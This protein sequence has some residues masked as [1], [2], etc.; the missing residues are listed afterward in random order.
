M[1]D[2]YQQALDYLYSFV[3]FEHRHIDQYAPEN[4]SLDRP[5]RLLYLLGD[6]H[7]SLKAIHIAGTKGKGSVAAMCAAS[8]QAAGLKVGLYTSPHLQSLRER[9]RILVEGDDDGKVSRDQFADLVQSIK[10]AVAQI[11]DLTWYELL[12]AMAFLH[13]DR[14]QVDIAVVEVGLG[15][16]LDATNLLTPLV[17]VITSLSLDHTYL[18]GDT[19]AEIAYEKGGII[20]PGVPVVTA[21]QPVE[22][23]DRLSEIAQARKAPLLRVGQE[24]EYEA[25]PIPGGPPSSDRLKQRIRIKRSPAG[26]FISPPAEFTLAL[27][28]AHQQENAVVALAALSVVKTGFPQLTPEAVEKG[29]GNVR[30]PG[31]LQMMPQQA[32]QPRVLLDCAHNGDSARKLADAL[33]HEF[34]FENLCLILGISIDKDIAGILSAL[35]PLTDCVYVTASDH[36]RAI[37]PS[38]LGRMAAELGYTVK[39]APT[40]AEAIIATWGDLGAGDLICITGSIFVVGNLLNQWDSLQSKVP[41]ADVRP[42]ALVEGHLA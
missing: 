41:D 15:G 23:I 13:F 20:K 5:A 22:A 8:L 25:I 42:S 9:I 27:A 16:R 30:W 11:P 7:R 17:S 24:W 37:S 3:N 33:T 6:P 36:P 29:L 26:A 18:L 39:E 10:P 32:G 40:V 31:R 28:G 1:S 14:Q 19:L 38:E 12:T 34:A 4:I 35:L 2:S 21:H